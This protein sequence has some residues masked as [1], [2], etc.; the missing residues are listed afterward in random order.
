MNICY[1]FKF[2]FWYDNVHFD[3]IFHDNIH[4]TYSSCKLY[5]VVKMYV[6]IFYDNVHLCH[7]L[8][9]VVKMY[10]VIFNDN[11]HLCHKLYVVV[12]CTLSS[13]MITYICVINWLSS[14]CT[15]SCL[16]TKYFCVINCTLSSWMYVLIISIKI[17]CPF[18]LYRF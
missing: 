15:S 17:S 7:K 10:V 8:Y 16:M 1:L 3:V 14:K 11:V 6:V 5:D 9:I 2:L 4:L 13:L 12:K 18:L